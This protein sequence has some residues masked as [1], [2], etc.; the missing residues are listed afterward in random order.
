MICNE[1]QMTGFYIAGALE[2]DAYIYSYYRLYIFFGIVPVKQNS[3]NYSKKV[4][5]RRI[6][7]TFHSRHLPVQSKQLKH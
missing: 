5:T 7:T 3:S 4:F 2:G 1:N 6:V